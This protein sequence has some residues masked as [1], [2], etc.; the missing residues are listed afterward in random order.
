M[1]KNVLEHVPTHALAGCGVC[2]CS[3]TPGTAILLQV[4]FYYFALLLANGNPY[5]WHLLAL[6]SDGLIHKV[7]LFLIV[8][9]S[10]SG[11]SGLWNPEC[12]GL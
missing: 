2:S 3:N 6:V 5:L 9:S 11:V 1:Y 12:P 4:Q 8:S 7:C 10:S